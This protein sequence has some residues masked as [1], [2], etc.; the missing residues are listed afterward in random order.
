M[1]PAVILNLMLIK[2][3]ILL[4]VRFFMIDETTGKCNIIC[5]AIEKANLPGS[6]QSSNVGI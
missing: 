5:M 1:K 2:K 4:K 3:K 6:I